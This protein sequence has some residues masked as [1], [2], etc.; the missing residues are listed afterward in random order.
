MRSNTITTITHGGKTDS[1]V[2]RRACYFLGCPLCCCY[3]CICCVCRPVRQASH[4]C[5]TP[6]DSD[7]TLSTN[8]EPYTLPTL[9][10]TTL[11]A[12]SPGATE[13]LCLHPR[14][15]EVKQTINTESRQPYLR[16]SY[17][18]HVTGI[19]VIHHVMWSW[20][21]RSNLLPDSCDASSTRIQPRLTN[22][23]TTSVS[24]QLMH[25]CYMH[26]WP[27]WHA[28]LILTCLPEHLVHAKSP[29]PL[30]QC[31]PLLWGTCNTCCMPVACMLAAA[32]HVLG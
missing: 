29:C 30:R 25:T 8:S 1:A 13:G 7:E 31:Q 28:V 18:P 20:S 15:M 10:V 5:D 24:T 4:K 16:R 3:W 11:R 27:T 12:L 22:A 32:A 2:T 26:A 19:F 9:G 14:R 21:I 6:H 17:V 23:S